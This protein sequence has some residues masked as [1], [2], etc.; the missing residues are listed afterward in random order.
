[1][2]GYIDAKK[3]CLLVESLCVQSISA[4][5]YIRIPNAAIMLVGYHPFDS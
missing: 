4:L 5:A 2:Q 1:M 3:A